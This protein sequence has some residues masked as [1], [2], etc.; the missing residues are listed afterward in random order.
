MAKNVSLLG[1]DYPDVP[2]VVLPQT[3]GG[4]A[5]FTDVS[6]TT[7]TQSDVLSGKKFFTSSGQEETGGLIT[8]NV[9]DGLNSNSATDALSAKQGKVL[10][11]KKANLLQTTS[12]TRIIAGGYVTGSGNYFDFFLPLNIDLT[13]TYNIS[14]TDL[15]VKLPSGNVSSGFGNVSVIAT[16]FNGLFCELA[17][18]S[19]KTANTPGT[20]TANATITV[21]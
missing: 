11:E 4:S 1:A 15:S 10:N 18:T 9:Y 12:L 21:S 2:A 13:K 3:G 8:H 14:V 5:T 17:F 6:G 16:Y 20:I 7:A 19:S